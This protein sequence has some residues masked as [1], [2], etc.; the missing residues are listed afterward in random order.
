MLRTIETLVLSSTVITVLGCGGGSDDGPETTGTIEVRVRGISPEVDAVELRAGGKQQRVN[1]PSS[2]DRLNVTVSEIPSGRT[3][4]E[5]LGFRG[6]TT[7]QRQIVNVVVRQDIVAVLNVNLGFLTLQPDGGI[8]LDGGQRDSGASDS[9]QPDSGGRDAGGTD[10]GPPDGGQIPTQV[11]SDPVT[12]VFAGE[13]DFTRF[14]LGILRA[15][16]PADPSGVYDAFLAD[17]AALLAQPTATIGIQSLEIR[18]A[19][20]DDVPFNEI[21]AQLT[22]QVEG[23][24]TGTTAL[25]SYT[26]DDTSDGRWISLTPPANVTAAQSDLRAGDFNLAIEGPSPLGGSVFEGR[27][28]VRIVYIAR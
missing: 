21:Y 6:G 13:S 19:G 23:T 26:T 1:R 2:S 18:L 14:G 22:L 7:I 8:P 27:I 28:E 10:V 3:A 5:V 12:V 15:E 24:R 4:V 25:V 11:L 9:G 20:A 16:K 17:A